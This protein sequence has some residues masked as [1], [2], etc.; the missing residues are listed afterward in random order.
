MPY[1][2]AV[3]ELAEL[4]KLLRIEQKEDFELHDSWLKKASVQDRKKNGLTWFPL[5]IV[6]T[7][8]GMG[9]YPYLVVERK[10]V[11]T[12]HHFQTGA[13]IQLFSMAD[14][15]SEES[16]NGAVVF[17]D[18]ARM[19][20]TFTYDDLP[21]WVD[22][23]KIGV[24][25]QFDSKTYDEMF[26][27]LNILINLEKGRGKELRDIILGYQTP[28]FDNTTV[29]PSVKLNASQNEA[30]HQIVNAQDLAIVHGPPG[31][32]KTTTLVEAISKLSALGQKIL[33]CAPSNAATDHLASSLFKSGLNVV[34]LGNLAKIDN[35]NEPL[36]LEFKIQ[37][38]RDFKQIREIKKRSV[39]LRRM[40]SKYKRS[41]GRAEAEQ[42]KLILHEA[43]NMSKEARELEDYLVEKVLENA[44][45]IATTLIGSASNY[46]QQKKFDVVFIDEAG[47][48]IEPAV[49]VPILKAQKVVMAGDPYQL[50]PTVKSQEA[51]RKG[52]T[53]TLLEKAIKRHNE[54]SLLK[55]QYRMHQDIMA[56]S[57]AYF[58]NNELVAHS[59]NQFHALSENELVLEFIDTAGCGYEEETGNEG[60]SLQNTEEAMLLERHYLSLTAAHQGPFSMGLLSPYRGQ[61]RRLQE[62]FSGVK[63]ESIAI[64]INTVDSFQGQERDIIYISLV[65]SNNASE[66]GF[67]KDYRRMNVAMTRAKKKLVMIGDSAT[68]GHDKFYADLIEMVERQGGYRT[69]WE[70]MPQ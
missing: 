40:A 38:E 46:L 32:G 12:T 55:V 2:D 47:Q 11:E 57:N 29:T 66:I 48:G 50:P 58:Y 1:Q 15:N 28:K 68:L 21:D 59:S 30:M 34:R 65:R 51:A 39:E 54:I 6:E 10:D 45:V 41:F 8:Y 42:R 4:A 63:N 67:L 19:K 24:N 62:L 31:T 64:T 9:D 5:R 60:E 27:A 3:Q 37:N 13:P 69:A 49:W 70:W 26:K 23:G 14:G 44:Q 18:N 20:L 22:D 53:I 16:I 43:K 36:T 17:A 52:L 56:Y 33:V 25:L 61:V 35:D 7:G